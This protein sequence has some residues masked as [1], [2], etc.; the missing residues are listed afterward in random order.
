MWVRLQLSLHSHEH[1]TNETL[2][3]L[4]MVKWNPSKFSC[5]KLNI[6]GS[7]SLGQVH[8]GINRTICYKPKFQIEKL[9]NLKVVYKVHGHPFF[10]N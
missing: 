9:I 3:T 5:F 1:N 2:K 4:H 6:N 10:A 8:A 7:A